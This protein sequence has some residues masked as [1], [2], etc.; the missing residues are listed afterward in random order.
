MTLSVVS[1]D[2]LHQCP[3][4]V[5]AIRCAQAARAAPCPSAATACS[6][7]RTQLRGCFATAAADQTEADGSASESTAAPQ[8]SSPAESAESAAAEPAAAEPGAGT[9]PDS[10]PM[11][12]RPSEPARP[13]DQP[14]DKRRLLVFYS[15]HFHVVRP[16][17]RPYFHSKSHAPLQSASP[18]GT[19]RRTSGGCWRSTRTTTM[20]W[21][22]LRLQ[23][24]IESVSAIGAC[25]RSGTSRR[26]SSGCWCST[27][28][29]PCGVLFLFI[30]Q[31]HMRQ[32]LRTAPAAAG[33]CSSG[34]AQLMV[35]RSPKLQSAIAAKRS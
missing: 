33:D 24:P 14:Q 5:Q 34:C 9:P 6:A 32:V 26:T 13:W 21:V 11:W 35:F 27:R 3:A 16:C 18:C 17:C 20:W 8:Q 28:P 25:P 7:R 31:A 29:L 30:P 19:S 4:F 15:D 10:E 23:F 12:R 22:S 1:S 2:L